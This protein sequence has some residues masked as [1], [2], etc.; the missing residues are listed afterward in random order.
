M[1]WG[2]IVF[3]IVELVLLWVI[4]KYRRRPDS[5]EP[6]HVHGNTALEITWTLTPALILV[7]IA[8]PTVRTIFKTQAPAPAGALQV[9]VTGHQW[10]WEFN[11]PELGITTANELYLPTGKTVNFTLRLIRSCSQEKLHPSSVI[12]STMARFFGLSK[13]IS[14]ST[15]FSS[16]RLRTAIMPSTTRCSRPST[17]ILM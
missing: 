10:W 4:I 15:V 6:A 9:Q 3:V 5:G 2:T 1:T 8:V 14:I 13:L 12:R 7:L 17:S 11:Y 16:G